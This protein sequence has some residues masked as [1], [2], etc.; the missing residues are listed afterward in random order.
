MENPEDELLDL[1][2]CHRSAPYRNSFSLVHVVF[3]EIYM[4]SYHSGH[5]DFH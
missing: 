5:C 2:T 3:H 4:S 1:L